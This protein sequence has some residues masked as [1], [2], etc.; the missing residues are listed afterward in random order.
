VIRSTVTT[1]DHF[2]VITD[3]IERRAVAALNEA[4][5]VAAAVADERANSPKPVARFTPI[6]A[7]NIGDGYASGVKA[8]PLARIFDRGSL[9]EHQGKLKRA[10]R[11]TWEVSRG[12]NPY[13]ARRHD[14]LAGKGVEARR[15]FVPA[16]KAG[17]EALLRR[18]LT[19]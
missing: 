17:R 7:R 8:G 3:A 13:T 14:D 11:P 1:S 15:I 4:A 6:P 16:R 10:R 2:T 9:G 12:A 19:R 18:L 5:A